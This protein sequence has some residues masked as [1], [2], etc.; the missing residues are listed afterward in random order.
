MSV[1][2]EVAAVFLSATSVKQVFT[3]GR[4]WDV[5]NK[6]ERTIYAVPYVELVVDSIDDTEHTSSTRLERSTMS[7]RL[8]VQRE[9]DDFESI[10]DELLEAF[11]D[12]D[13]MHLTIGGT[14]EFSPRYSQIQVDVTAFRTRAK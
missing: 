3:D 14:S 4:L 1:L 5:P 8:I 11:K 12:E 9:R 13:L 7:G 2:T 6:G 10:K